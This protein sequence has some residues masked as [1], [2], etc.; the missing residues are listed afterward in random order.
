MFLLP[1]LACST[2]YDLNR[3]CIQAGAGF[4]VDRVS[5]L[6]DAA[7]YPNN[8][9]AVVMNFDNSGLEEGE[10]WRVTQVEILAMIP[11]KYFDTYEGGDTLRVDIW[12]A[13]HPEGQADWSVERELDPSALE[14]SKVTLPKDAF[15]ASQRGE[16]NQRRAWMAFDFASVIPDEGLSSGDYTVGVKWFESGLPTIGYS[17]FNLA[18]NKNWTDYGDHTWVLNSADGDKNQ[19]SWPMMRVQTE[20]RTHDNGSCSGTTVEK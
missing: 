5:V 15:W 4:D 11:E 17:N 14:W 9:D 18:C 3:Y 13:D 8:R 10:S 19:C 6:Q 7:G 20:T 12:D 1:L 16:L 2:D